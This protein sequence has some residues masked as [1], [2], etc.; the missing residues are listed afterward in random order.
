MTVG[1]TSRPCGLAEQILTGTPA[2]PSAS[3]PGSA[4]GPQPRPPARLDRGGEA[5][6]AGIRPIMA[7]Q[8]G[9]SLETVAMR[10]T[11]ALPTLSTS[12][13]RRQACIDAFGEW[14]ALPTDLGLPYRETGGMA[15]PVVL[16]L[17]LGLSLLVVEV[18]LRAHGVLAIAGI[19]ALIAGILLAV[20][21]AMSG[22]AVVL[23]LTAP[24]I[25]GLGALALL[26]LRLALAAGGQAPR[27]GG[28][29]LV[30]H[31]GVVRRP[32][33]PLGHVAIDGELW[34]ARRSWACEE[35]TPAEGE[36]VVVDRVDGLT[37]SVRPAEVWEVET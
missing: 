1:G 29:G 11:V 26:A 4:R 28:E 15:A 33:D 32:L 20:L 10:V 35:A 14:G 6:R 21:D 24:L 23:A 5:G 3:N 7:R 8:A 18:A 27:C 13:T 31:I 30:G 36:P 9:S 12:P 2:G 34:R 17:M 25:A 22:I 37:L 16:L 19:A